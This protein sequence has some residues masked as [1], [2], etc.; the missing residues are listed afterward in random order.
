MCQF[1][2]LLEVLKAGV[3][4]GEKIG[5]GGSYAGRS[6]GVGMIASTVQLITDGVFGISKVSES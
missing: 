2:Q 4:L 3:V 1:E 6:A 5:S